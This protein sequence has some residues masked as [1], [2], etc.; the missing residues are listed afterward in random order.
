MN[1]MTISEAWYYL[2]DLWLNYKLCGNIP[3]VCIDTRY[4]WHDGLCYCITDLFSINQINQDVQ[5]KMLNII[6]SQKS[7][8][9]KDYIWPLTVD[10]AKSRSEFCFKQAKLSQNTHSDIEVFLECLDTLIN[11][12]KLTCKDATRLVDS[13]REVLKGKNG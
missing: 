11:S 3:V 5:N 8:H 7:R 2:G 10:G 6:K 1:Q 9:Y 4:G 12:G 13:I